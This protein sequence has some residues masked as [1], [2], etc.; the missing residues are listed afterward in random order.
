MMQEGFSSNLPLLKYF[1]ENALVCFL[2]REVVLCIKQ[3][4]WKACFEK[5]P[6][7]NKSNTIDS[8]DWQYGRFLKRHLFVT[9][10]S[11]HQNSFEV[12]VNVLSIL[13][14]PK[15]ILVCCVLQQKNTKPLAWILA[16]GK[17]M[18]KFLKNRESSS[19]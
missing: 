13:N 12:P 18:K 5:E 7:Q 3:T 16:F 9:A 14:T 17:K 8:S 11:S 2:S 19:A 10:S 4:V 6:P 1:F 15:Q